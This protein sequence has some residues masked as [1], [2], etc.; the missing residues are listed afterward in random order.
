M[1]ERLQAALTGWSLT[2]QQAVEW[3]NG[4]ALVLAKPGAGKTTVLTTRIARILNDSRGRH[5]RVLALNST[6]RAGD[7]M[8]E[9]I[10]ALAPGLTDRAFIGTYHSFCEQILRQHGSHIGIKPNFGIYD[11]D[12]DRRELLR[13]ALRTAAEIGEKVTADDVRWL[14]KIDH[15]RQSL[16]STEEAAS[17]FRDPSGGARAA[18][19]YAIYEEALRA[20][21]SFDFNGMILEACRLVRQLP[22]V[23]ARIRQAYPYWLIDEFQNTTPA[24]YQL[25]G[26]LAGDSFLNVFAVA[27]D[28]PTMPQ[29][30]G[31]ADRQITQFRRQFSPQLLPLIENQR[32]PP[33]IVQCANNLIRHHSDGPS[34]KEL[35][36]ATLA[37]EDPVIEL[38]PFR[39]DAQEADFV[40]DE[41]A[42]IG[43]GERS[44]IAIIGRTRT[45]LQPVLDALC[46]RGVKATLAMPLA[47]LVS[48]Q[49]LWLE[50]CLDLAVRPSDGQDFT[51]LATSG[52]RIADI[53]LDAALMLS[54]AASTG[55]G[56]LE[57]W[58]LTAQ[59]NANAI[60]RNL[61][62]IALELVR[63]RA[64]W[65]QIVA[66]AISFLMTTAE[67]PAG[68]PS[69][70]AED[71]EIWENAEK[72]I[73]AERGAKPDIDE[74][75]QA[76]K[77]RRKESALD[78]TA[79][80]LL[81]IHETK[82]LEFDQVWMVGMAETILPSWQSLKSGAKPSEIEEERRS[83]FIGITRT[84]KRLVLT[85]A[86]QYQ[87]SRKVPS[88]FLEEM[89]LFA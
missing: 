65:P 21:N 59:S 68:T 8:R 23:G 89:G 7:E 42:A 55:A 29:C 13:D 31:N 16:V 19:V 28:D 35:S 45:L 88:R 75:V 6:T 22:A 53:E 74:F 52:N 32:C 37:G 63:S 87:G 30:A 82:G 54:E 51:T 46:Q 58:A 10:E 72:T 4:A 49:F 69:D 83:C 64:L 78:P 1:T 36:L 3:S 14:P 27:N 57:H 71:K 77:M 25:I 84:R 85:W 5:F 44:H 80:R 34:D 73:R 26:I 43:V 66:Q 40:A 50:S 67:T 79:V 24:Q 70:A 61:A 48:P 38:Q 9:R 12:E 56:Y 15:L 39:T 33:I 18:H 11:Q 41:I 81:P 20:S 76:L 62:V 86:E 2:Q 47:Q 60:A 17:H